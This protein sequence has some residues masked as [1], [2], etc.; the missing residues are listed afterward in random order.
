MTSHTVPSSDL[1]IDE[2]RRQL[3]A[4]FARMLRGGSFHVRV[5]VHPQT[6]EA[7]FY[8]HRNNTWHKQD[9]GLNGP[10]LI[11]AVKEELAL[12]AS[13]PHGDMLQVVKHAA[14]DFQDTDLQFNR[15][16]LVRHLDDKLESFLM[17]ALFRDHHDSGKDVR[18]HVRNDP[19]YGG[20]QH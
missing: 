3:C 17:G 18:R 4:Q 12:L 14:T 1:P 5:R 9:A 13:K 20:G 15:E 6:S 10:K 19:R 16:S 8:E 2:A 7:W 11:E